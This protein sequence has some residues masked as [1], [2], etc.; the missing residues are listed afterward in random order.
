MRVKIDCL[1]CHNPID[2]IFEIWVP[3]FEL[4]GT[5]RCPH[6]GKNWNVSGLLK[7]EDAYIGG[8][9]GWKLAEAGL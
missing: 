5:I 2:M 9:I 8:K 4:I 6:C 3:S 1:N 7:I